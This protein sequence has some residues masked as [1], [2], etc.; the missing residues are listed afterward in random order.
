MACSLNDGLPVKGSKGAVYF[1]TRNHCSS[2][3]AFVQG[4]NITL[5]ATA[6]FVN[7]TKTLTDTTQ[8]FVSAGLVVG[9]T[10]TI[11]GT[12]SNNGTFTIAFL[13]ETNLT[14]E[15]EV[16]DETDSGGTIVAGAYIEDTTGPFN[17][18]GY[19]AG[20]LVKVS[21]ATNPANDKN[22]TVVS[23]SVD[24]TQLN[25]AQ[26]ISV[27]ESIGADISFSMPD[28]GR[29][30]AGCRNWDTS[31]ETNHADTQ[32][33]DDGEFVTYEP[34]STSWSGSVER[35]FIQGKNIEKYRGKKFKAVLYIDY[36]AVPTGAAPA[37]YYTGDISFS[38]LSLAVNNKEIVTNN[39]SLQGS[40]ELVF[41]E[42][43]TAW[44]T[45]SA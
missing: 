21:G 24:G 10:I 17:I 35:L 14:F 44:E 26:A 30:I 32:T 16:T 34:I 31:E 4:V 23:V 6:D 42:R 11:S 20:D 15:E 18:V 19:E 1:K 39:I 37:T 45:A 29:V 13:D 40:G 25:V 7:A 22:Y 38:S 2:N 28:P 3:V 27:A 8:T 36:Q 41:V 43:T 9:Q 12:T 5:D 33:F